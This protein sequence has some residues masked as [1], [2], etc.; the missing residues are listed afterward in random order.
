MVSKKQKTYFL[1]LSLIILLAALTLIWWSYIRV[2]PLMGIVSGNGRLEAT[3][4]EIATKFQG[5]V[6]EILFDEGDMVKAGEIVARIDTESLEAQLREAQAMV[7]KAEKER[8]YA[9]ALLSQRESECD[10]KRKKLVRY[11]RLYKDG[12]VSLDKLDEARTEVEIAAASCD[13]A[14]ARIANAEA[15]VK[16]AV[17]VTERLKS[18]IEDCILKAPRDSRVQYRLAEPG[19]VLPSG[20]KILTTID[21]DDIYMTIFLPET[22]AGKVRIGSDA[23]ITLDA[24]PERAFAA[25]VSFVASKAQFTPKEVETR[26]ER[27]KLSF[28]VKVNLIN[29]DDLPAKPGMPGNAYVI[30][31]N[32]TDWPEH[33][34]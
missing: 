12:I 11:E 23:R 21:L 22:E 1:I 7:N 5:R 26:T 10:L 15:S 24:F 32:S 9:A 2:P 25:K 17:S 31:G 29:R 19:E 27:Q 16:S 34:K 3:E 18:D 33:L 14:K 30:T 4:I 20:G 6:A 28:R 8:A 13:A